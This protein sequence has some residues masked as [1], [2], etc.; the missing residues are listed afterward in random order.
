MNASDVL[1]G[2]ANY[3]NFVT[4]FIVAPRRTLAPFQAKG[5]IDDTLTGNLVVG[6]CVS[7]ILA[8]VM[9]EIS[10]GLFGALQVVALMLIFVLA[11]LVHLGFQ[12]ARLGFLEKEDWA[13]GGTLHDSINATFAF[14]AFYSP[15]LTVT[16][17]LYRRAGILTF[18]AF[19]TSTSNLGFL[20]ALNTV[21]ILGYF[22]A[23]I[24]ATHPKTSY[25]QAFMSFFWVLVGPPAIWG[26][27]LYFR[28]H[29]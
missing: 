13:V 18:D 1:K 2:A 25:L 5:Q 6:I 22:P 23:A 3:L 16:V 20:V 10:V 9:G 26:L 27:L 15:L 8:L 21:T 4:G 19:N 14:G 24:C 12:L 29:L 7:A 11:L 28:D 17:L